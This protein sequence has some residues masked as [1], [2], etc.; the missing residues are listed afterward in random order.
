MKHIK[1]LE[2]YRDWLHKELS[3]QQ[4]DNETILSLLKTYCHVLRTLR[5]LG[6]GRTLMD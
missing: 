6:D 4:Q 1:L 2:T 5:V 3:E